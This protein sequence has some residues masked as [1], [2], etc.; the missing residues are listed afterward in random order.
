M[1]LHIFVAYLVYTILGILGAF[2]FQEFID[3]VLSDI[4]ILDEATSNID[5]LSET[6]TSY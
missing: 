2:Y 4:L 6:I 5:A 3:T 1:I